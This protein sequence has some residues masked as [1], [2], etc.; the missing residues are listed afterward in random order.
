MTVQPITGTGPYSGTAAH[1]EL[2]QLWRCGG[3]GALQWV[4]AHRVAG[5]RVVP[6]GVVIVYQ[7]VGTLVELRERKL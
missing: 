6:A 1:L 7:E 5:V 2:A 3:E 4:L